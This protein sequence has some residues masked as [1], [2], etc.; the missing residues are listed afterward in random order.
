MTQRLYLLMAN[1]WAVFD[2]WALGQG[3]GDPLELPPDRLAN[4]IYWWAI[5]NAD[6]PAE[7]EK[8]TVGLWR[9]PVGAPAPD[10]GPWSAESE[11]AALRGLQ[12]QI[13]G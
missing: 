11:M 9:P 13:S 4:L 7:I 10:Q 6:D 8:W 5:R 1:E 12:K 2:G 3:I